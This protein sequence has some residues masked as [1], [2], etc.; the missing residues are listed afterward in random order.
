MVMGAWEVLMDPS[1]TDVKTNNPNVNNEDCLASIKS[2][3]RECELSYCL[4]A[5]S[6]SAFT[7]IKVFIQGLAF[8]LLW[9]NY[10]LPT[11]LQRPEHSK[12]PTDLEPKLKQTVTLLG[13]ELPK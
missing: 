2:K 6:A 12:S 10:I 11:A 9:K 4:R 3:L 1:K 5:H 13:A 7:I 8:H